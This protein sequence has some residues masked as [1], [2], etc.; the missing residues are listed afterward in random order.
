[1]FESPTHRVPSGLLARN[2]A[3]TCHPSRCRRMTSASPMP[4]ADPVTNAEFTGA[5]YLTPSG[6]AEETKA[7][8]CM[9]TAAMPR[10][11][12]FLR[13][14]PLLRRR[15]GLDAVSSVWASGRSRP[16]VVERRRNGAGLD[17]EAVVVGGDGS[18]VEVV[19]IVVEGVRLG[20]PTGSWGSRGDL[21][22]AP[23]SSSRSA[24]KV[25]DGTT[26]GTGLHRPVQACCRP[27]AP[28]G[29]IC[30]HRALAWR[31]CPE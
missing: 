3:N 6:F 12:R 13:S 14:G 15:P 1:M 21:G 5:P 4:V 28:M 30:T 20:T 16:F 23:F 9:P 31:P 10:A 11:P 29:A 19:C 24:S 18:Q 26:A 25:S 8:A 2:A 22:T 27:N 17:H 7:A